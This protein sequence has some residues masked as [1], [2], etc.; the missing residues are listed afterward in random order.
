MGPDGEVSALAP[1]HAAVR[2][3]VCPGEPWRRKV[4]RHGGMVF[5]MF[6]AAAI[7][8]PTF[9]ETAGGDL[10]GGRLNLFKG[11]PTDQTAPPQGGAGG[12]G[13]GGAG[14]GGD[15]RRGFRRDA[16]AGAQA[17]ATAAQPCPT[18]RF[19]RASDSA[20]PGDGARPARRR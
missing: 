14:S 10:L 13:G 20:A 6:A 2:P 4:S 1:W 9:M 5:M 16:A 8:A 7:A 19:Q 11:G 17:A 15:P 12:G 18:K 3:E